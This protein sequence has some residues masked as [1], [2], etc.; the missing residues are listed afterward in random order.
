[1]TTWRSNAYHASMPTNNEVQR[2]ADIAGG[3]QELAEIAGVSVAAVYQWIKGERPV[4]AT[5]APLIEKAT[6]VPA[7]KLCPAVPW[8]IIRAQATP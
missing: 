8:E 3:V 2:A 5:K 4:P 6:G 1:M 7:E